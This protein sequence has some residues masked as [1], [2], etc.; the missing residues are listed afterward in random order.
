MSWL[1]LWQTSQLRNLEEKKNV[2]KEKLKTQ[3]NKVYHRLFDLYA[4][5]KQSVS[6]YSAYLPPTENHGHVSK[7]K[8]IENLPAAVL[9]PSIYK[10]TNKQTNDKSE[11]KKYRRSY[12]LWRRTLCTKE[13][14]K[15]LKKTWIKANT[16]LVTKIFLL[17]RRK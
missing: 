5:E 3:R 2:E 1:P 8:L 14:L 10:Q 17:T 9:S 6:K 7:Y 15:L 16:K 12:I 11:A 4:V 13:L